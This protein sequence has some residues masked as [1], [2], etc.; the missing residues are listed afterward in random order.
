MAAQQAAALGTLLKS[1]AAARTALHQAVS[2][3]SRC[4]N[5]S[6]AVGQLQNVVS[7][8]SGEYSRAAALPTSALPGGAA[9]KS[10]LLTALSRSLTADRDFLTWAQHQQ[11]GGCTPGS[12]SGGYQA[13]FTASLQAEAA[14]QAFVRVWNPV[15]ARY[16]MKSS[17]ADDI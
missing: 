14:K 3:V 11:G 2:Q 4:A 1:S 17:S 9:V 16:G 8:R 12:Q 15:A 13:A 6:G 10:Q 7:Q 5:L